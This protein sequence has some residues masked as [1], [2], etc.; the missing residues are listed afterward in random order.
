MNNPGIASTAE[1]VAHDGTGL[2]HDDGRRLVE[3][4]GVGDVGGV[5]IEGGK[6]I[7][8]GCHYAHRMRG[9]REGAH[10]RAEVLPYHRTVVDVGD[11][12]VVLFLVG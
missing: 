4:V 11:E 5:R 3:L 9:A 2:R 12:S 6:R 1:D 10:E 7:D 8:G